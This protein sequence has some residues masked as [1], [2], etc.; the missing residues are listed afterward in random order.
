MSRPWRFHKI[1]AGLVVITGN[2]PNGHVTLVNRVTGRVT[3]VAR[4][5]HWHMVL[6]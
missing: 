3:L 5:N 1:Q 2:M 4:V 6:W